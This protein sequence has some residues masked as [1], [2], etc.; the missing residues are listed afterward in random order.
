MQ[1]LPSFHKINRDNIEY[2]DAWTLHPFLSSKQSVHLHKSIQRVGL[3]QPPILQKQSSGS[4]KLITGT[5]RLRAFETIYP[6]ERFI[7]CLIIAE[8]TSPKQILFYVLEDQLLSGSLTPMEK[9]FFF[10]HCLKHMDIDAAADSFLP[11]LRE[12]VQPHTIKKFSRLV[13]LESELQISVHNGRIG[14]KTAYELLNLNSID[15]V[16]LHTIFIDLKLGG[17]KQKRFLALSK[18]L[19]YR[20][21]ST[22]AELLAKDEFRSILTHPEMNQ[23]QKVAILLATMQKNLFPQSGSAEESFRKKIIKMNLPASCTV[24]HSQS[25]EK[26]EVSLTLRFNNLSE[27]EKQISKIRNLTEN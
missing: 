11:I 5:S 1:Q 23:P 14:E 21:E 4:Y 16:V 25:F 7:P 18:D 17:G 19:A 22:I 26:D 27:I 20:E 12:K 6:M 15:R 3:L 9:A 8:S 13:E 10:N 2:S 24:T